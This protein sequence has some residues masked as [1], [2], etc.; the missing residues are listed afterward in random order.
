MVVDLVFRLGANGTELNTDATPNAPFVDI[1]RVYGFDSA[2]IRETERDH[3]GVDGGFLDAEFEKGRPLMMDGEVFA[4]PSTLENYLDQLKA[5]WA[6]SPTP[7]PFFFKAPGQ[8]E[9]L[10]FVKPRGLRYDWEE[11]R[12]RGVMRVQFVFY[13]EDPRIYSSTLTSIAILYGGIG[14]NGFPFNFGFDLNFGGGL[15]PSGS[16]VN[17]AGNRST[18]ATLLIAGPIDKPFVANDTVGAQLFFDT[19]LDTGDTL[20]VDTGNKTV[21][22]NGVTNRR[23]VL[24]AP[25]WFLLKPGDNFIRFGGNSGGA[26]TVTVQFRSAWR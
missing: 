3:E 4:T 11:N 20:I 7:V 14:G 17:N 16:A 15:L 24:I 2:P 21:I 6:P 18:P 12:R 22:L 26:P 5:E 9:R 10:M 23:S 1:K 25:T 8:A 19:F 13:G